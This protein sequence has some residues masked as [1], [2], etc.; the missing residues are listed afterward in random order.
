MNDKA[1]VETLESDSVEAGNVDQIRDII[2]GS[3]MRDYEK[4]F[5]G[6]EQRML[7]E[8]E[9]LRSETSNRLDALELYV[10]QEIGSLTD[11]IS[12]ERGEREDDSRH[13][14]DELNK[15]GTEI[16][17]KRSQ[18]QSHVNQAYGEQRDAL[19]EQSKSLL[20]EIQN[21]RNTLM[22][23]QHQSTAELRDEK[24]D[25]KALADMFSEV[26]MRLNGDFKIVHGE[27]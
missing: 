1:K 24:A 10:K 2:F 15:H 21:V 9:Q 20:S 3:Q 25:R 27:G 11:Q 19:L 12:I 16:E 4:R 18:L 23:S 8:A 5:S 26:A 6:L 14:S 22:E 17:K 7:S 13:L